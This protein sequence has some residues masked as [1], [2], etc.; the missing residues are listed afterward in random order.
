MTTSRSFTLAKILKGGTKVS[1]DFTSAASNNVANTI[2]SRDSSG[3]FGAGTITAAVVGNASTATTLQTARN[4][5]ISGDV[6]GNATS[7]N[8]SANITISSAITAGAI[9]NDDINAS[10]AIADTKLATISTAGKVSNSATTATNANTASAIVARDA[11]GNFSAGTITASLSGSATTAG[12]VT[13]AAQP[14][15]TSVGTL[16]SLTTSGLLSITAASGDEGGEILL[17]KPI[18]NTSI[19]GTGV[20]I[21]IYQ[22][23]IRFFEQGGDARGA[24][25]DLTTAAAGANTNI[26][27]ASTPGDGTLTLAVSGTGLSGSA[28]FTANQAGNSTF[29]VTSNATSANTANTIVARDAS[30]NFSAGTIT[31][32]SFVGT[33]VG[34]LDSAD[35]TFI[36]DSDYINSR[37]S[38][39]T[40]S[41]FSSATSLIIYNSA[42]S[43]VKTIYSPGS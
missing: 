27:G 43:A 1:N 6:T 34:V 30:G 7:F 39:I 4:I 11:S 36:V 3:N 26:L 42:G 29:T 38:N 40:S 22:N 16:T 19:A 2:V 33:F 35:V 41:K 31:A 28:T 9:V 21:D 13:T 5:A 37:V 23:R 8:G 12:T 20:T 17:A 24:Y 10:A 32:T 14:N 15:I 18:T 25:I